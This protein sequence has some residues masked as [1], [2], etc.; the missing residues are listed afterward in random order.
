MTTTILRVNGFSIASGTITH[1]FIGAFLSWWYGA[2]WQKAAASVVRKLRGVSRAFSVGTLL[3]TL[4]APWRRI[5]AR[6]GASINEHFAAWRDNFIGRFVGFFVRITVL[7]TAG[8]VTI[9]TAGLGLV[10]LVVWPV[11]PLLPSVLF[12]WGVVS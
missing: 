2:G 4:F 11:L 9:I 3:R 1:M 5:V 8:I 10:A 6:P 12:I 7:L